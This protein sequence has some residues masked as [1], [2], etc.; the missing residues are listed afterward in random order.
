[1]QIPKVK[2]LIPRN[3]EEFIT[4][5]DSTLVGSPIYISCKSEEPSP[6]FPFPPFSDFPSPTGL[7]L[8]LHSPYPEVVEGPLQV[9]KDPLFISRISSP[10]IQIAA[11]GGGGDGG[12]AGGGG[13]QG[14]PPHPPNIFSKVAAIYAPSVLPHVLYNIR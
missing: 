7:S 5:P 10:Q 11:I 8:E 2:V 3:S 1:L 13:G 4:Y 12:G 9:Y 6:S 14:T